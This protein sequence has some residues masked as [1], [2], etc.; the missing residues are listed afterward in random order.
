[1]NII[2][3]CYQGKELLTFS[4]HVSEKSLV[5]NMSY[6]WKQPSNLILIVPA[7]NLSTRISMYLKESS[8]FYSSL[9]LFPL[10]GSS[11]PM[12]SFLISITN[13]HSIVQAK[14]LS[15][16]LNSRL[17]LF[18]RLHLILRFNP[19]ANPISKQTSNQT[20][21][22]SRPPYPTDKIQIPSHNLH[23]ILVYDLLQLLV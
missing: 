10:P 9:W 17:H 2:T 19:L 11:S 4:G 13:I 23:Q 3:G 7:S 18:L 12:F 15:Y 22:I 8:R 20:L 21:T 1:M 5:I 6:I 14:N 16:S